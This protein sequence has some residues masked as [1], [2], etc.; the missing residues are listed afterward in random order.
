MSTP[1][2]QEWEYKDK[3]GVPFSTNEQRNLFVEQLDMVA[4][5]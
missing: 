5:C 3:L 4:L 1:V 2:H